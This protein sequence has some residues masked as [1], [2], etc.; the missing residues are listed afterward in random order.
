LVHKPWAVE[1]TR[2][3]RKNLVTSI[4][5]ESEELE[6]H[7]RAMEAKYARAKER[8]PRHELYLADDADVLL[9]GFGIVSRVLRTAAEA[10]RKDG[11]KAGVFR[12]ITLWPFPD[13]ALQEAAEHAERVLVVEMSNGQLVED[14][15]LTLAG[16]VPVD[17]YARVGGNVPSVEEVQEVLAGRP[18]TA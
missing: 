16:E 18:V 13:R 17:F 10:T 3:T 2:A 6:A 15:R 5:L 14:V 7:Q 4:Y 12:P 11:T 9:V 8:E 1:G